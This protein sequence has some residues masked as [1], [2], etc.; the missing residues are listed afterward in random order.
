MIR[1]IVPGYNFEKNVKELYNGFISQ[2]NTEFSIHVIDDMSTDTSSMCVSPCIVSLTHHNGTDS[3]LTKNTEKKYAL[4]NIIETA[5]AVCQSGDIVAVV[6]ADDCLCNPNTVDLLYDAYEEGN[7]VVWTAHRW[8]VNG[9]NIS[10]ELPNVNP[11]QYPWCS[12]HLRTFKYDLLS[13][14]PESNFQ[15]IYG[16]WFIR[17]YDQ[18]LMLPVLH[19]ADSYLYLD[20]VCYLYKIDSVSIP[21]E[22]RD[23]NEITQLSTINFVR[24]RGF[25]NE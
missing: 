15:D 23:W 7:D 1:F 24:A 13:K 21:K 20:E 17:G 14:I 22:K 11:Y 2:R 8:D 10:K 19:V 16:D 3:T 5:H 25:L 9:M 12:S 18:A 6:D 4:K